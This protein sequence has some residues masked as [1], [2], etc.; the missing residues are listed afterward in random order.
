MFGFLGWIFGFLLVLAG[1]FL[2]FFFPAALHHQPDSFAMTGVVM[3]LIFWVV[4]F[5]LIFMP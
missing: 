4:G 1:I 3:G 5:A 2:V